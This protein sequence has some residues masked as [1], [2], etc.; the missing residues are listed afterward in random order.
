MKYKLNK[1]LCTAAVVSTLLPLTA[2][3]KKSNEITLTQE[4]ELLYLINPLDWNKV[5]SQIN[6]ELEDNCVSMD[7]DSFYR[8]LNQS[9]DEIRLKTSAKDLVLNK[10][11]IKKI[12]EKEFINFQKPSINDYLKVTITLLEGT[13]VFTV[14]NKTIAIKEEKEKI[15]KKS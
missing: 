4:N 9:G 11:K 6:L 7:I 3:Q 13:I 10:Q 5:P 15:K 12:M 14:A 1:L 8:L 2:C